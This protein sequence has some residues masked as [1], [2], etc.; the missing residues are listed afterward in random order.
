MEFYYELTIEPNKYYE[1]FLDLIGSL[2]DEGIEEDGSKIILRSYDNPQNIVDGIEDFTMELKSHLESDIEC[3]IECKK[4]KNEDWIANYKNSIEPIDVGNFYVR[5]TWCAPKSDKIE[6][7]I[8]PALAFGS[9]HHET[10]SSC[11]KLIEKY[12]KNGNTLLDVG[13]GSGILAIGASKLGTICDI[14]DTDLLAVENAVEN[15]ELNGVKASKFWEGSANNATEKYDIVVANIVADVLVF[16]HNDLKK[17]LKKDG[18]LILSGIL[19]IHKDKVLK[20]FINYEKLDEVILNEWCSVVLRG[21]NLE[22][23]DN[24]G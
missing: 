10:T 13:C 23:G 21:Q 1:L 22:L 20:K 3:K 24:N 5:P 19:D 17:C 12:A 18:V 14:C 6:I 7:I 16:I 11:L 15:F 8:D 4:L 9:G 2:S